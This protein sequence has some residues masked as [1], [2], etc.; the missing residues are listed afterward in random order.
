VIAATPLLLSLRRAL[1]AAGSPARSA[2]AQAYM[3]SAMP[4]HGVD[5]KTLRAIC[6]AAFAARR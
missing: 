6:K 1:A 5:A 4:F 3:K 2:G